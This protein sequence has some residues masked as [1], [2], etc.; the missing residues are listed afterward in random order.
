MMFAYKPLAMGLLM[1]P[2]MLWMIHGQL[3]GS[4]QSSWAV[5]AFVGA[6]LLI[7]AVIVAGAVFAAR[8]SPRTHAFLANLHRPSLAH[9]G[10]MLMGLAV[11]ALILHFW[12]HGGL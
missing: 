7:L 5:A 9:V 2:M 11:S 3:T 6:H 4:A 12:L 8:L 10:A 1:G